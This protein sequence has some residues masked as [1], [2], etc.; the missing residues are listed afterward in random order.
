M[1]WKL[2]NSMPI[3]LQIADAFRVAVVSGRLKTGEKLPGVREIALDA[4]VNPNTVQRGLSILEGEKLLEARST[5]GW[6][7]TVSD[8]HIA[9]V[10][11]HM[12]ETKAAEYIKEMK[13]LGARADEAINFLKLAE[14]TAL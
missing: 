3:Y 1:K 10:R 2:D 11:R 5:S 13:A 4:G 7:V 6:Y 8:E 14:D 9:A 12:L